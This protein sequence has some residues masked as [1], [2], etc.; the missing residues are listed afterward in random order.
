MNTNIELQKAR[1]LPLEELQSIHACQNPFL[2]EVD[3]RS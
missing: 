1:I 2:K 3:F